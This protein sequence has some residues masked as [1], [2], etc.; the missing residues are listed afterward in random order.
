MRIAVVSPISPAGIHHP[1]P[2]HQYFDEKLI[3]LPPTHP[4][5]N[6]LTYPPTH[7]PTH[8]PTHPPTHPTPQEEMRGRVMKSMRENFRPEFINR[9]DEFVIFNSLGKDN[10]RYVLRYVSRY[11]LRFTF[12]VLR[13]VLSYAL[14]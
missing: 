9:V 10:L 2:P 4:P 7:P 1:T 6:P 12:Y 8:S 14:R 3:P 11:V 5:N 13:Y